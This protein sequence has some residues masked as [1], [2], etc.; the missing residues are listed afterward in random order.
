M[1]FMHVSEE[2]EINSVHDYLPWEY[3]ALQPIYLVELYWKNGENVL[4]AM[5]NG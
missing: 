1:C 3:Y 5:K 2:D 4:P